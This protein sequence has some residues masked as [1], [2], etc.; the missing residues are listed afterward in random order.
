MKTGFGIVSGREE[1]LKYNYEA[2][3]HVLEHLLGNNFYN[4]PVKLVLNHYYHGLSHGHSHED[5][6][7]PLRQRLPRLQISTR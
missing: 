5:G 6:R 7:V 2:C 1:D 4:N 3:G